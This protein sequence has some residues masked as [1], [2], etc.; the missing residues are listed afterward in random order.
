MVF[1]VSAALCSTN[2]RYSPCAS[3]QNAISFSCPADRKIPFDFVKYVI[4]EYEM[5]GS[6]QIKVVNIILQGFAYR[7]TCTY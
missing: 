4:S 5:G 7:P 2:P 1:D 6:T 3:P